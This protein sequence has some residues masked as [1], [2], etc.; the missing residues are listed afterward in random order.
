MEAQRASVGGPKVP[1]GGPKGPGG[2]PEGP[3]GPPPGARK[4]AAKR[5][6]FLVSHIPLPIILPDPLY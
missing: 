2:W 5:P 6:E 3:A 1:G 4:R